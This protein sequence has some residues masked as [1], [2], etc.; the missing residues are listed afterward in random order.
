MDS[1]QLSEFRR[2]LSAERERFADLATRMSGD[3][4]NRGF[5]AE[6]SAYDNHP[7]DLATQTFEREKD[8]SL[9]GNNRLMLKAIDQALDRIDD[10][11]YGICERCGKPI[12]M[13]RLRA[14][15]MTTFCRECK[16]DEERLEAADMSPDPNLAALWPPFARTFTDGQDSVAFDGED[17]WQA[18]A[19]FGTSDSPQDVGGAADYDH[20]YWDADEDQGIVEDVEAMVDE[21]GEPIINEWSRRKG[22]TPDQP[23]EP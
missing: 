21:H 13:E 8:H 7:A 9:L 4:E 23:D 2:R 22:R 5:A 10:G 11:T 3:L 19:R 16:R 6:E 17:A 1:R 12:D 15:P 18:V 20:M 14:M